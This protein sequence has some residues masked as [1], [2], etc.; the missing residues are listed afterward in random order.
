[1]VSDWEI[2]AENADPGIESSVVVDTAST[3]GIGAIALTYRYTTNQSTSRV[4]LTRDIQISHVPNPSSVDHRSNLTGHRILYKGF[5]IRGHLCLRYPPGRRPDLPTDRFETV[6]ASITSPG[7]LYPIQFVRFG[8][9]LAP[10]D[11]PGEQTG[12]VLL[13]NLRVR[14]PNATGTQIDEE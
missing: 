3:L 8:I 9:Q 7:I 13:D 1:S 5:D 11:E 4:Y 2:A 14:Y 6:S 10:S 12:S